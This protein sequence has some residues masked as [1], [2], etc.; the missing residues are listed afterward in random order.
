M[1]LTELETSDF[2]DEKVFHLK[3]A[4]RKGKASS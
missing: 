2:D 3:E 1:K 4:K